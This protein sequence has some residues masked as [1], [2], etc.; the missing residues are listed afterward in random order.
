MS[1]SGR[2]VVLSGPSCIGKSPLVKALAQFHPD[3]HEKLQPLVLYNSRSPRPGEK[4]EEDYH[5]RRREEIE[6]LRE[7]ENFVVMEVRGDLLECFRV[8][9]I[10]ARVELLERTI[11]RRLGKCWPKGGYQ[12]RVADASAAASRNHD[13]LDGGSSGK[14]RLVAKVSSLSARTPPADADCMGP[15]DGYMPEN[16]ARDYLRDLPQ[17]ELHI[18]DGGHWLLETHATEV[19]AAAGVPFR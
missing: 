13:R 9:I 17:A 5:F 3:L 1:T 14:S 8:A 16:A 2:L 18:L 10:A 12:E 6:N 4:D 7:K 19:I 11:R 15:Q